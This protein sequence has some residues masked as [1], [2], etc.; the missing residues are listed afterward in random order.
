MVKGG[1]VW[2]EELLSVSPWLLLQEVPSSKE[3]EDQ[4]VM[5]FLWFH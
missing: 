5:V 3:I 2:K 4:E 1:Q